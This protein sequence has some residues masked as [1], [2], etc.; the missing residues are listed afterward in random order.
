MTPCGD[1]AIVVDSDYEHKL[2]DNE[3][4]SN[5][6]NFDERRPSLDFAVDELANADVTVPIKV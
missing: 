4:A 5:P 1:R 6:S 3:A 2:L